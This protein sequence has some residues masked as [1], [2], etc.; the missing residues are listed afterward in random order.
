MNAM[1]TKWAMGSRLGR[2][3]GGERGQVIPILLVMMLTLFGV[4]GFVI[5]AG[6]LYISYQELQASTDAAALAG[7]FGLQT[8]GSTGQ[9]YA[10]EFDSATG[11]NNVFSNL[12]GVTLVTSPPTV[13][14]I[15]YTYLPIACSTA[16]G[17]YNAIQVQQTVSVPM[18]FARFFG[19]KSVQLTAT[20]TASEYGGPSTPYNIALI[21]DTTAS[22]GQSR[23]DSCTDPISGTSYTTSIKCA[24]VGAKILLLNTAP[25]AS[26]LSTCSGTASNSVDMISLFTFPNGEAS[27]MGNDYSSG[28][29]GPT[30]TSTYSYPELG[31]AYAPSGTSPDYQVTSYQSTYRTS[32]V[33]TTLNTSSNLTAAI[34]QT[35]GCTGL[36]TPGGLGTYYAGALA[37]AQETLVT[38]QALSG[39]SGSKNAIILLSD[40]QANATKMATTDVNG[41]S[42]SST[43][44]TYPSQINECQQAINIAST[45][46]ATGTKI[47]VVA[48]GSPTTT[49]SA[50]SGCEKDSS[51]PNAWIA[52]CTAMSKIATSAATFF[53]DDPAGTS[54]GCTSAQNPETGL[55]NIFGKISYNFTNARLIPNSVFSDPTS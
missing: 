11:G 37:A 36:Q 43:A 13:K 17:T 51:G 7:G 31:T 32:D 50:S 34:G 8:S 19:A 29:G 27:T 41:K 14:C 42:V 4:C 22:M 24:L 12:P 38:Q 46:S 52:P 54:S 9:T 48:Y 35:S 28:C 26:N 16:S 25:C 1:E 49:S 21:I 53:V 2:C 44:Y 20:S 5:D 55:A 6:R 30:I 15:S 33:A 23:S 45:I 39:R 40:G 47:Y 3:L 10:E 18:T